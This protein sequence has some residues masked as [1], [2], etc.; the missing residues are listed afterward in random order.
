MQRVHIHVTDKQSASFDALAKQEGVPR[1]EIIRKI[2]DLG[3]AAQFRQTRIPMGRGGR[4]VATEA[5][6]SAP[7]PG[8]R[9]REP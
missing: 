8:Q 1:S 9:L 5:H 4:G 3:L 6:S 7:P 2:I